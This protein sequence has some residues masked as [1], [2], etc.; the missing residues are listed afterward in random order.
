MGDHDDE[1]VF[2]HLF[3]KVHDLDRGLRVESAG[4][5]VRQD[6]VGVVDQGPGDGDALH[7]TAGELVRLL[8]D[9]IAETDF[10]E[11]L[12]CP[13]LPL[14]RR[15]IGDGQSEFHVAE[16]ALVRDE[17]VVLEHETDRVVAVGVP[18]FVF[19]FFGRDTVDDEVAGIIPVESADDVQ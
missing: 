9:L 8:V 10:L 17:I 2:G 19:V 1:T 6:D 13:G 7:L 12:L 11:R 3:Q 16:D 18:V 14:G 15:D 4:G 5:L